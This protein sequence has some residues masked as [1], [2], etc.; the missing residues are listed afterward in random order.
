MM[1]APIPENAEI[2]HNGEF[3]RLA[4]VREV[5]EFVLKAEPNPLDIFGDWPLPN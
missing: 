3:F 1:G 2:L 5:P 4:W